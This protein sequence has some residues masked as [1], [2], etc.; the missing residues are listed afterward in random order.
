MQF[1]EDLVLAEDAPRK[2]YQ[3]NA[4]TA[5]FERPLLKGLH[6]GQRKLLL[7]EVEFFVAILQR[8]KTQGERAGSKKVLIVYAGAAC[9]LHLPF[10]FSLFGD[11]QF[12]LIDPAPFCS[13]VREIAATEGSCVLELIEG[14]CT[15]ELCLRIR[16]SYCDTH[17]LYLVSDIRSG[18]PTGMSKNQEHTEMIQQDNAAQ[19]E[20]CFSLEV[21]AA[22]LKFHPPYPAA[23]DPKSTMYN[24]A[25]TTAENYVYLSGTQL[26]G[27]WAPKSSSEVRLVVVGPFTKGYQPPSRS[28]ACTTHEEQCYA[29]N[30]ENRYEKDCHAERSILQSYLDLFPGT[31]ASAEQLSRTL[32]ERLEY[33]FFRPLEPG[34][35]EQHAR[36]VSLLY[37]TGKPAALKFFEPLKEEMSVQRVAKLVMDYKDSA[38]IPTGVQISGVELTRDFWVALAEA[39]FGVYCFPFFRW[40][41]KK[42]LQQQKKPGGSQQ[43]FAGKKRHP[44]ES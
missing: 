34:F 36:W 38:E 19:R 23:Q 15:P 1:K 14:M 35:T 13:Q 29:Y 20:W 41:W 7:S 30:M 28:Y 43:R 11:F 22:M 37:S 21:E 10:L 26:L 9:G 4:A 33:P 27:V 12:V 24:A 44:N 42:R 25:D 31:Y 39:D 18:V 3:N 32:S 17:Q 16:R 6:Y 40:S 5:S 2:V 8:I